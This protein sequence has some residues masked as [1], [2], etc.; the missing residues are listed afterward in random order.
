MPSL[1]FVKELLGRSG[2]LTISVGMTVCDLDADTVMV[3]TVLV[4]EVPPRGNDD[5]WDGEDTEPDEPPEGFPAGSKVQTAAASLRSDPLKTLTD[6]FRGLINIL[7][8]HVHRLKD[9]HLYFVSE[10][11]A[12]TPSSPP[13]TTPPFH[14]LIALLPL[15]RGFNLRNVSIISH[16]IHMAN[17]HSST[18]TANHII[19]N[20]LIRPL[21]RSVRRLNWKG[22]T[23]HIDFTSFAGLKYLTHVD[24]RGV[25]ASEDM[26][27]IFEKAENAKTVRVH[28]DTVHAGFVIPSGQFAVMENLEGL[29]VTSGIEVFQVLG[30][31][32][33]M[34]KLSVCC[35][36]VPHPVQ[37]Q[38]W[39]DPAAT[40]NGQGNGNAVINGGI[41]IQ[42]AWEWFCAFLNR[43][44]ALKVLQ[45]Y[46]PHG[47][48]PIDM[49][50]DIVCAV[51]DT[52][53]GL[54][55]VTPGAEWIQ[56]PEVDEAF[57]ERL[58]SIRH[59]KEDDVKV[60]TLRDKEGKAWVSVGWCAEPR[61]ENWLRSEEN[62]W[63]KDTG[64]RWDILDEYYI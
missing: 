51:K 38:Q 13:K 14:S 43:C 7:A 54:F 30:M 21:P 34:P 36:E 46:D 40:A 60:T 61:A 64:F 8:Q 11:T 37:K 18:H 31:C 23:P 39:H 62:E 15:H 32:V 27:G 4:D 20:S 2:E 45:L 42:N 33:K 52:A 22:N 55:I 5:T 56:R 35:I 16:L 41:T 48:I 47:A 44:S 53:L 6:Y 25:L 58:Q 3:R 63:V 1:E 57:W 29:T 10:H 17:S 24:V 49:I 19:F 12:I 26:L 9:F 28:V 59:S 50:K